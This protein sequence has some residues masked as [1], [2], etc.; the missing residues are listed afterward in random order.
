MQE[1]LGATAVTFS[2]G[3]LKELDAAVSAI[4]IRGECLPAAVMAMSGVEAPPKR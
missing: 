1:N 4:R 2:A 3:E